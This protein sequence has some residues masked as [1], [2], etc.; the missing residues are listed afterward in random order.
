LRWIAKYL[1]FERIILKNNTLKAFFLGNPQSS[2]FESP[3]FDQLMK[4]ISSTGVIM[5]LSLKQSNAF[6]IMSKANVKN[7][8]TA[9]IVLERIL[10]QIDDK[11]LLKAATEETV[12]EKA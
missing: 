4:F 6:L 9:R 2:Y 3:L 5:G 1:G 7:L 8:K 12:Q 10:E 11:M